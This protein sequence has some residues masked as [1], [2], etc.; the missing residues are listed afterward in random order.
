MKASIIK[1]ILLIINLLF[2]FI[3]YCQQSDSLNYYFEIAAKSNPTV[4]QRFNEFQASL[5]K[6]P[7][8]G[9]LP[10]PQLEIGVYLN[11][12]ELTNGNQVA[13]IKLMQMFP[14]YGVIK[15]SKDEMSMMAKAKFETFKDAKLQVFYDLQLA[16]FDLFKIGQDIRTS[17]K[18]IELLNTIERLTLVK[19]KSGSISTSYSSSNKNMSS[20]NNETTATVSSGMNNMGGNSSL[21]KSSS[22]TL[23]SS[24]SMNGSSSTSSLSDLYRIQIEIG[25]LEDKIAL[26]KNEEQV[27]LARFN[28]L[29]NRP[30]NSQVSIPESL[31][32]ELI[33]NS[34]MLISDTM[35]TNNPMLGML[36]YEKQ[37]LEA[38]EKMVKKMGY[39]MIGLG[40]N[41]SIINK[42]E[43]STS[44][45]NGK[46]MIMPMIT[47]T[48]PVYRKKYKAMKSEI[49]FLKTAS[50][51]NYQATSN[52]L[53]VQY[54]EAL[55]LYNDSQRRLKL[56]ENQS[57]LAKKTLDIMIKNFSSSS[58][59]MT[60]ILRVRQQLF[61]YE[62]K[63]IEA[64]TE[65]NKAKAQINR[66]KSFER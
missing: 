42:S 3:G 18:N 52:F 51:Q 36:Q 37:S 64:L 40:I 10:D 8:V 2:S 30:Q 43:M 65:F 55:Q 19:Y 58:S 54:Y 33:D 17:E 57:Q 12:M 14:W 5:Q 20:D 56:Y 24:S 21:N 49:N 15:N 31:S 66:L 22:M 11:S 48:L 38:R 1:K 26:L 23:S 53:Q 39:P 4:L 32:T 47:V 61:D 41:Y 25:D 6:V 62:F 29:L 45:M 34:Y 27:I 13:D 28:S 63:N 60:D 16:W 59:G 50:E 35:F 46:D 9:S 44:T 7:Q